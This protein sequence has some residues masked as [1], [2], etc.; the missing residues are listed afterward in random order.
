VFR[1]YKPFLTVFP[2]K[3]PDQQKSYK[4]TSMN[5]FITKNE[6]IFVNPC[7]NLRSHFQWLKLRIPE[8]SDNAAAGSKNTTNDNDNDDDEQDS[9]EDEEE[10]EENDDPGMILVEWSVY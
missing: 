7:P 1:L 6:H 3:T 10:E 8:N 2:G 5:A 9:E 4:F